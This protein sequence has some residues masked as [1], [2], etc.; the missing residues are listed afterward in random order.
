[1][2]TVSDLMV[3]DNYTDREHMQKKASLITN[4]QTAIQTRNLSANRRQ[5]AICLALL[6]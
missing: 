5:D 2:N 6:Q 3:G 1:M 4:D